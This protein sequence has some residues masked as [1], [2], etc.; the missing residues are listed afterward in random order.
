MKRHLLIILTTIF[1]FLLAEPTNEKLEMSGTDHISL[2]IHED[3]INEF[4]KNM[5]P[6]KGGGKKYNWKLKRPR[7]KISE[8][9]AIFKAEAQIS[10]GILSTTQ[11]VIGKVDISYD[12]DENLILIEIKKADLIIDIAGLDI[13]KINLGKQFSEPIKFS[14]PQAVSDHFE[15][16]LSSG[17]IRKIDIEVV[18]YSLTLIDGA[19]KVSTSLGFTSE[20]VPATKN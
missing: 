8:E 16:P 13:G 2:L 11:D 5:G 15:L 1:S 3:L 4:F 12:K 17:E 10:A 19:I 20:T 18:S 14:G 7:I 9:K 6:I